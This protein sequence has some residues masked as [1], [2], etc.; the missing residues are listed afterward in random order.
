MKH[1]ASTILLVLILLNYLSNY[2]FE[3]GLGIFKILAQKVLSSYYL[4][5][6]LE[7]PRRHEGTPQSL[8]VLRLKII[9]MEI[10][11]SLASHQSVKRA[12]LGKLDVFKMIN[13]YLL[14]NPSV[15]R[16][17]SLEKSLSLHSMQY[18]DLYSTCVIYNKQKDFP[19]KEYVCI[20]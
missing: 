18:S 1:I 19:Q 14:A 15:I 6:S 16:S 11:N 12:F 9:T 10:F 2:S 8:N 17:P 7:Y 5:P 20:W 13:D 4:K 3:F